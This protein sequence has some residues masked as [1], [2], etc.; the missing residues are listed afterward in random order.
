[1]THHH[2][3]YYNC[4]WF[5]QE[6]VWL[7]LWAVESDGKRTEF[8]QLFGTVDRQQLFVLVVECIEGH[9]KHLGLIPEQRQRSVNRLLVLG[10][11]N[12]APVGPVP[13]DLP[14]HHSLALCAR[15][16]P[17]MATAGQPQF[18]LL[19][20]ASGKFHTQS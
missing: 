7:P 9:R 6:V 11:R 5:V 18:P 12:T 2:C 13:P 10:R 1:M 17:G 8:C 4:E 20:A 15:A 3:T 14:R 19:L 16:E